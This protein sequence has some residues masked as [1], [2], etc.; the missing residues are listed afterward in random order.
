MNSCVDLP[1]RRKKPLSSQYGSGAL[2]IYPLKTVFPGTEQHLAGGGLLICNIFLYINCVGVLE[3]QP[4]PALTSRNPFLCP[5]QQ[6][7]H[8]ENIELCSSR[9]FLAAESLQEETQA[10]LYT[11]VCLP[12]CMDFFPSS[13]LRL[14]RGVP[15]NYLIKPSLY[16]VQLQRFC[17]PYCDEEM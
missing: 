2:L 5:T 8:N 17:F 13:C 10:H 16:G 14:E 12:K 4:V 1:K 15:E 11:T 7:K 6:K 9:L 3:N